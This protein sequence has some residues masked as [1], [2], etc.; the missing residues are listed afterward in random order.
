MKKPTFYGPSRLTLRSLII[1]LSVFFA[2][3]TANAE[4]ELVINGYGGTTWDAI[5]KYIHEPY[6]ED[7]GVKVTN[8]T[9]P[10]LAQLKAMV[11]S[12]DMIYEAL[13][14]NSN[15]YVTA[16]EN[17]W[18]EK[19]DYSLAD[20]EN[21]QPPQAK[22]DYGM[23]F[24]TYSTILGYRTDKFPGG[25]GPKN[26]ADFW[27]VEKFPGMRTMQNSFTPSLELALMADGVANEDVYDVLATEE[28][29][30]RAFRKLDEIKPHVVKWW[31]AGAE[32]IQLLAEGEVTMA[33]AWNGR[34]FSLAQ[35]KPVKAVW[36]QGVMDVT[37]MSIPKGNELAEETMKYLTAW[38]HP[39][40]IAQFAE[41]TPYP[42]LLPGV[43][44]YLPSALATEIP[45]A[46]A[47]VQLRIKA[48]FWHPRRDTLTERWNTW[49]LE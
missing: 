41:V 21:R 18:L 46:N 12:G 5:A 49:L 31:T 1:G 13:E 36:N 6:T 26:W 44:E 7:T 35:T 8:T 4:T 37:Y 24:S 47:D 15:E 16:V 20:P 28:G 38:N 22:K 33:A 17:G 27:N 30:D 45:S 34:L 2:T 10:N 29:I 43:E 3:S 32:P 23:V 14:L 39:E 25:E 48:E 40:R 11:E 42:N 19:I 9:Q